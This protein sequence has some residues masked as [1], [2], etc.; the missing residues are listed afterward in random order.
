MTTPASIPTDPYSSLLLSAVTKILEKLIEAGF[1]K[2]K[3]IYRNVTGADQKELRKTFDKAWKEA[4][5]GKYEESLKP[6]FNHRP[7]QDAVATGLLDPIEGFNVETAREIWEDKF[8]Q[9]ERDLKAFFRNLER[10]LLRDPLWKPLLETAREAVDSGEIQKIQPNLTISELVAHLVITGDNN[11]VVETGGMLIGGQA[12]VSIYQSFYMTPSGKAKLNQ[13]EF[14]KWLKKYLEWVEQANDQ[15]RLYGIESMPVS[16]GKPNKHLSDIF[17]P[18]T[19]RRFSPLDRKELE[20]IEAQK[21]LTQKKRVYLKKIRQKQEEGSLVEIKDLLMVKNRLAV[22]GGPG[23]GKSTLLS[24]LSL[25]LARRVNTGTLPF[26]VPDER[27]LLVPVLIPLRYYRQY[28]EICAQGLTPDPDQA[29]AGTLRGFI[30]WYI[31]RY[32]NRNY[33]E[34]FFDRLLCGGGCLLMLDGLDEVVNQAERGQV[35]EEVERLVREQYPRN[36]VIVTAREAGY[37]KDAVFSEDFLRLDVQPLTNEQIANLCENWCR[38]LYPLE[39]AQR[40]DELV[41]AIKEINHRTEERQQEALV[42][43]PLLTS[44][45]ISVKYYETELPR[46]RARLYEAV[47]RVILQAQYLHEDVIREELIRQVGD[48]EEQREWLSE[49]ALQMH[50]GGEAGA[51]I[52]EE[53][54]REILN[55][56]MSAGQVERFVQY[57]RMRGG[58]FEERAEM[59]Q[60]IHLSFQ[61]FLAARL[62]AKQRKEAFAVLK[63][64]ITDAW[65]REVFML[66]YGFAKMDYPEAAK[67]YLTWLQTMEGD[68]EQVSGGLELAGSALLDVEKYQP[69]LIHDTAEKLA[70]VIFDPKKKTS[71]LTR[72]RSGDTL[73]RLG[74]PRFRVDAWYFPD[75]DLLGFVHIPGGEFIMGSDKTMDKNAHSDEYS[76]QILTLPDYY[77]ARYPVTVAQWV[78]FIILNKWKASDADSLIGIKNH[79]VTSVTWYEAIAYCE[80]LKKQLLAWPETPPELAGRLRQGWRVTLPSEAEWERAARGADGRLCPWGNEFDQNKANTYETG[81][82]R[83]SPVGCFPDGRSP[84]GLLDMC[85]N[86][87]EWTRSLYREYPY[88]PDDG[89]EGLQSTAR[90]VLRGGSFFD[91]RRDVR[92]ACR[93]RSEPI[94]GVSDFGFRVVVVSPI[95]TSVL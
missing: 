9:Y 85:G 93:R 79:P 95:L 48:W 81:I 58:L 21:E 15:A 87:W 16:K 31:N 92:C 57:V 2:G 90:R 91:D 37:Q 68:D 74:D 64:H 70:Q 47:V 1:E 12:R 36:L 60:F 20:E 63:D 71:S 44:M 41:E 49:L 67:D 23:C 10:I 78:A 18:V 6:L 46:E 54:L 89:R 56:M 73:A 14:D 40:R 11:L 52:S 35:R 88:Q 84:E 69:D 39:V 22:I 53:R 4:S 45:V 25:S 55:S 51:V 43:S 94:S 7:F 33:P 80:W 8:P 5:A 86:V 30:R 3:E 17:L 75:E 42:R 27:P 72:V 82:G 26:K 28:R 13:P 34:D 77:M 66:V 62:L 65:W 59:F 24:Y 38:Q 50:R 19:L 32:S 61:E 76:Q 29:C 83:T